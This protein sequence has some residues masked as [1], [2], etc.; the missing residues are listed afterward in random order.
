MRTQWCDPV[1]EPP[2]TLSAKVLLSRGR[3]LPSIQGGVLIPR[4]VEHGDSKV[5]LQVMSFLLLFRTSELLFQKLID[6]MI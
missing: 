5:R 2:H 6:R 4:H 1:R 3:N